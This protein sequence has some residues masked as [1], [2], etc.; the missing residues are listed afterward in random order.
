MRLTSLG[1]RD[2]VIHSRP[3]QRWAIV[4]EESRSRETS[5]PACDMHMKSKDTSQPTW[6]LN[7][8][9]AK[10]KIM[11]PALKRSIVAVGII[12]QSGKL[13]HPGLMLPCRSGPLILEA[14]MCWQDLDARLGSTPIQS[15]GTETENFRAT[16]VRALERVVRPG[17]AARKGNISRG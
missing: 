17:N 6:K 2:A 9:L 15:R 14:W 12:W 7:Q 3:N 8:K 4:I 13:A 11:Q 10:A 5:I 16:A 1:A